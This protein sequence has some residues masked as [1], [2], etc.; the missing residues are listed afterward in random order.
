MKKTI[1]VG[2]KQI[3]LESNAF[4]PLA[5][6]KQFN[7]DFFQ[8]LFALARIFKGKKELR[9][10]Q[11]GEAFGSISLSYY[12]PLSRGGKMRRLSATTFIL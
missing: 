9:L 5:Y 6:K 11:G 8:E 2:E 10:R 12:T 4:T 7:K 3:A 1:E